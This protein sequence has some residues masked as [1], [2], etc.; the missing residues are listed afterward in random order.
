MKWLDYGML[1]YRSINASLL[2]PPPS[3]YQI[4]KVRR[5]TRQEKKRRAMAMRAKELGSLGMQVNEKGQVI[6]A[7]SSS[8]VKE[9]ET[10]LVDEAG[11]KC[12]IC[13]EGYRNQPGKVRGEWYLG[14]VAMLS[15][16]HIWGCGY[17]A[18]TTDSGGVHFH[19]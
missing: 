6:V 16:D 1:N 15:C 12:C 11:L 4:K 7:K 18:M 19:T 8:L 5:A 13:M 3:P 14:S 9:I 2:S 17:L 10:E